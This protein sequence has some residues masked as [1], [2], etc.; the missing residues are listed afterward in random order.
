M[1][2]KKAMAYW[3]AVCPGCNMG[4][5]YP[6]S[7]IGKKVVAHCEKGCPVREAYLE[8]FGEK[9]DESQENSDQTNKP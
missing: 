9:K 3:S 8:V 1:M 4:R 7:F 6:D 5:K 2:K